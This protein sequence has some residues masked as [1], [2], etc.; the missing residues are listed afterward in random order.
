MKL[1]Q[2]A[3]ENITNTRPIITGSVES[4]YGK[5]SLTEEEKEKH[6]VLVEEASKLPGLIYTTFSSIENLPFLT[7][8]ISLF[9]NGSDDTWTT[10]MNALWDTGY[11]ITTISQDLVPVEWH[12]SQLPYSAIIQIHG[13]QESITTTL[14]VRPRNSMPNQSNILILGQFSLIA[15]LIAEWRGSNAQLPNSQINLH[16]FTEVD[17]LGGGTFSFTPQ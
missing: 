4:V 16:S 6:R 9:A 5:A 14:A 1:V 11:Q 8:T 15:G 12:N 10:T 2:L 17:I 13:Y 7:V 3:Q